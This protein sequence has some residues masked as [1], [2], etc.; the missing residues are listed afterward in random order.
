MP[1]EG[2]GGQ[3]PNAHLPQLCLVPPSSRGPSP[4]VP[5]SCSP[6]GSL[7]SGEASSPGDPNRL[8]GEAKNCAQSLHSGDCSLARYLPAMCSVF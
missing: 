7:I 6:G 5:G 2:W 1:G 3:L 8:Q 4:G